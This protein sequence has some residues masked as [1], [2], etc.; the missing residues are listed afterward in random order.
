MQTVEPWI[1]FLLRTAC[2]HPLLYLSPISCSRIAFVRIWHYFYTSGSTVFPNGCR[3]WSETE[4]SWAAVGQVL[5]ASLHQATLKSMPKE[6]QWTTP[7]RTF[8]T[9]AKDTINANALRDWGGG[10]S[11]MWYVMNRNNNLDWYHLNGALSSNGKLGFAY[12]K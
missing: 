9:V 11:C 5:L 12:R 3:A 10:H 1:S 4:L 6:E 8:Q 7:H 2:T